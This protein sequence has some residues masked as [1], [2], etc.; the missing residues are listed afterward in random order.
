MK[1]ALILVVKG[2]LVGVANII[3]GVSGG[4]IALLTGTYSQLTTAIASFSRLKP[5]EWKTHLPFLVPFMIGGGLGIFGF[6]KALSA[7][8]ARYP[9]Q[10]NFFFLGIVAASLPALLKTLDTKPKVSYWLLFLLG[11][12][13]TLFFGILEKT[14]IELALAESTM[15]SLSLG[16]ALKLFASGIIA[17]TTMIIPGISGSFMLLLLGEYHNILGFVKEFYIVGLALV[18]LG[19]LT[20]LLG[21][22]KILSKLLSRHLNSTLMF[23]CGLILASLYI[24]YPGITLTWQSLIPDVLLLTLGFYITLRF[25]KIH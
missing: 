13:I 18:A 11:F 9:E 24:L 1:T 20:G 14:S 6:A 3:P 2:M 8:Y 12:A 16:Y 15:R 17:A 23:I 4:T 10:V 7:L 19:A 21:G 22:A 5:Q 25:S